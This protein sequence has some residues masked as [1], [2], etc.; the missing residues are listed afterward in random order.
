MYTLYCI[1][2]VLLLTI[3]PDQL[4]SYCTQ[5]YKV[6]FESFMTLMTGDYL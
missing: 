2:S 3:M 1:M 6:S 5:S 4:Y